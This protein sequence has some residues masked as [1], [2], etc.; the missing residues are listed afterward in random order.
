MGAFLLLGHKCMTTP[1]ATGRSS[2]AQHITPTYNSRHSVQ[3][4]RN[5]RLSGDY[6]G[7]VFV[8]GQADWPSGS[9]SCR[10]PEPFLSTSVVYTII[11]QQSILTQGPIPM[12]TAEPRDAPPGAWGPCSIM[13]PEEHRFAALAAAEAANTG[14]HA[15]QSAAA[16]AA[17]GEA[18]APSAVPADGDGWQQDTVPAA[19]PAKAAEKLPVSGVQPGSGASLDTFRSARPALMARQ[20]P[21]ATG[22]LPASMRPPL[23]SSFL[24]PGRK[25]EGAEAVAAAAPPLTV[26]GMVTMGGGG[27]GGL[28][29]ALGAAAGTAT[30]AG[31]ASAPATAAPPPAWGGAAAAEA[32]AGLAD[33]AATADIQAARDAAAGAAAL[34]I[35]ATSA[36]FEDSAYEPRT[37]AAAGRGA[38][39]GGGQPPP[40]TAASEQKCAFRFLFGAHIVHSAFCSLLLVL[41]L[42]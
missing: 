25:L 29:A 30:A 21:A 6:S 24:L 19:A 5:E 32:A 13:S 27:D 14:S 8:A 36:A 3:V 16:Y 10:T 17:G 39:A 20:A 42:I 28:D 7:C 15:P 26:V 11:Q 2:C 33:I 38:V 1:Q 18:A 41:R 23:P 4:Q 9:T 37:S 22:K 31:S 34:P 40:A 35:G 12:D